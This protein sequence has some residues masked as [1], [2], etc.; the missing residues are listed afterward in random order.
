MIVDPEFLLTPGLVLAMWAAGMAAGIAV[1]AGW[2]IVGPA[3]FWVAGG[4]T[5]LVGASA[6]VDGGPG[7]VVGVVALLVAMVV[8][9][10]PG[11]LSIAMG[12]AS[13][14]FFV[15]AAQRGGWFLAVTGGLA[16]GLV[17]DEML[18]GH[19]YLVN[20]KLPRWSLKALA[21]AG[22]GALAL[23]AMLLLLAGGLVGIGVVGWAF[24]ALIGMSLLLMVG[25]W[26]AL[27]EPSYPGVMA[28]TGL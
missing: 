2:D 20:P 9:R 10:R 15:E 18:L 5:L 22:G 23:D 26:F 8:A 1:I 6:M 13:L 19:W 24:L 16:V 4:S 28:A 3:F 25:V 21:I 11:P 14:G 7:G 17:T 27:R 12:L